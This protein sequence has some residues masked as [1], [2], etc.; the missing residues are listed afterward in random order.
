MVLSN[1]DEFAEQWSLP[2]DDIRLWVCL[3]DAAHHQVLTIPHVRGRL[4]QLLVAYTQSFSDGTEMIE[5]QAHDLGL[6]ELLGEGEPDMAAL[7]RLAGD[8]DLL[9]GA[10]QSP[11]QREIMP[12]TEALVAAIELVDHVLDSIGGRLLSEYP[13]VTEALRRRRGRGR[14]ADTLRGAPPG[15]RVVAIDVRPGL[16][17]RRRHRQ[18]GRRSP[19]WPRCWTTP[20]T[21]PPR[22][23][24]TP[25]ASGWRAWASKPATC[26]STGTSTPRRPRL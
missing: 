2:V 14:A 16:G 4:E 12:R 21:C 19:P 3:S 5:Q 23:S 18:P 26:R 11:R 7:Q 20:N 24:S 1:V 15:P 9:L 22:P 25:P 8:P 6:T 13:W 17:V 10:M